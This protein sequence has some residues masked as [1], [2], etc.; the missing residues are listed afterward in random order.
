MK[1]ISQLQK[2]AV[3]APK[4][5]LHSNEFGFDMF[6]AD[7]SK[8]N[9][10]P[11]TDKISEALEYAKGFDNPEIKLGYWKAVTGYKLKVVDVN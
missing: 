10:S 3:K 2:E 5:V 1:T 4:Y 7:E 11:I 9:G 8:S 6:I